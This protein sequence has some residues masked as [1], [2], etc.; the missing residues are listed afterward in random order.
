LRFNLLREFLVMK[1]QKIWSGI[2]VILVTTLLGTT[3]STTLSSKAIASNN[4]QGEEIAKVKTSPFEEEQSNQIATVYSYKIGN[5]AAATLYVRSIPILTFLEKPDTT[6]NSLDPS[7]Q[8][9]QIADKINQLTE[10]QL[11]NSDLTVSWEAKSK[12]FLLKFNGQILT[13]INDQI[14]SADS[15]NNLA[16]DALNVTNRLRRL[17]TDSPPLDSIAG[18]PNQQIPVQL[19]SSPKPTSPA[20]KTNVL[21]TLRGLASWYGPGFHGRRTASGQ[22]F[23]QNALTAAH[24]SLPFGTKVRVTNVNN[25][26]STVVRINDRGPYSGRRIIDLS[27]GAARAIGLYSSGVGHVK[28][29]VLAR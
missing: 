6:N 11:E 28:L 22:R 8:A 2:T 18:F 20:P 23:N 10:S 7:F 9:Q 3:G 19:S 21:K 24:R 26:R 16:E 12:S 14:K 27:A 15:T 29:E 4:N 17:L 1:H 25:G 5:S 13:H